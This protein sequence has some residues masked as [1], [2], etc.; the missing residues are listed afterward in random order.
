MSSN[1]SKT[2]RAITGSGSQ[3]RRSSSK[4]D[5]DEKMYCIQH[6]NLRQNITDS[7]KETKPKSA[8][9]YQRCSSMN[10]NTKCSFLCLP[11]DNLCISHISGSFDSVRTISGYIAADGHATPRPDNGEYP[12]LAPENCV[13]MTRNGWQCIMNPSYTLDNDDIKPNTLEW[14]N[15]FK[16]SDLLPGVELSRHVR[17]VV[18]G[19]SYVVDGTIGL[20][21]IHVNKA[22]R[23]EKIQIYRKLKASKL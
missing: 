12:T 19:V 23:G 8:S 3:C 11:G 5:V 9:K 22:L 6:W 16:E 21:G 4:L 2:C 10:G 20:C 18:N 17:A 1:L 15:D 13:A 14:D 7:F